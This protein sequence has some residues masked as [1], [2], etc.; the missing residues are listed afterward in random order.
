MPVGLRKA[1]G[2]ANVARV[3][4]TSIKVVDEGGEEREGASSG[5]HGMTL[6]SS[7]SDVGDAS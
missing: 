1:G 3:Q 5:R 2:E 6:A 4:D 7:L